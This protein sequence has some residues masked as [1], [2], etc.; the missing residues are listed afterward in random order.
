[1]P[2]IRSDRSFH[3]M[4]YKRTTLHVALAAG[5]LMTTA[6]SQAVQVSADGRGQVLLYPYYTTRADTAGNAYATLLSVINATA[7]AKAIRVRFLEGK[8]SR[9]VTGF[10]LFLSPFDVWTA[11]A[12]PDTTSGGAKIGTVDLSCTLPAFSASPIAPFVSF[13]NF[14]YSGVNDD[15]AGTGLERGKEGYFEIIE[16]ATFASSSITGKAVTHVN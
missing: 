13:V 15:G 11:A 10:N 1:M 3:M 16:M 8:N 5:M 9:E 2:S 7:S 12:L 14:T 6:A 4:P